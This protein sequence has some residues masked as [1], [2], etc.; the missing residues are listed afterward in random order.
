MAKKD[1]LDKLL[2]GVFGS[3]GRGLRKA[4]IRKVS[5]TDP[6]LGK[7]IKDHERDANALLKKL[8]ANNKRKYSEEEL[9]AVEDS[10]TGLDKIRPKEKDYE[11]IQKN[12][13]RRES[14]YVYF[15]DSDGDIARHSTSVHVSEDEKVKKLGIKRKKGWQYS[16]KSNGDIVAWKI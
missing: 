2:D 15:I 16:V 6:E 1:I 4:A 7:Q 3:L 11:L 14:G 8:K 5:R 9:Q 10:W 12:A 13:I